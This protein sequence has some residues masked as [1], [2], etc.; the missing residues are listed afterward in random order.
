[1]KVLVSVR[2]HGFYFAGNNMSVYT[3]VSQIQLDELLN[4]YSLSQV[5]EFT[6][7][8]AGIEN[9]NYILKTQTG[10]YVLT[11][12]EHHTH[13]EVEDFIA[14]AAH[15]GRHHLK[16]PAPI[17]DN[18]GRGLHEVA[19]KP[20]IICP[21]LAGEHIQIPDEQDCFAIGEAMAEF[22][23]IAQSLPCTRIDVRHFSWWQTE[24][25]R[26]T[27]KLAKK[28]QLVFQQE[29]K[30]Q[31]QQQQQNLPQGWIH[32]DMFHDNA[33]MIKANNVTKVGAI[34]DLYNACEGV[35]IYDLAIIANDWC[36]DAQDEFKPEL[37]GALFAGYNK[38][39][40]LEKDEIKAFS[41]MLRAAAL[42]FWLSRL[43]TQEH[44]Q[45]HPDAHAISKD[46]MQ[47]YN[48]LK[49]RQQEDAQNQAL[50]NSIMA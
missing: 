49:K 21:F 33:L 46:P 36:V 14:L 7:I 30:H 31:S 9:T 35:F 17:L 32:G 48:K 26:L 45:Q 22:H 40:Q 29:L 19:D 8:E 3:Q 16:V 50:L 18:T 11:L 2:P 27:N 43:L 13:A 41:S 25:V 20:A 28:L 39:R 15:L 12:F 42:R 6:G 37:L 34:L 10:N 4:R 23:Q 44:Q 24:G 47:F 1:M 5:I 38:L